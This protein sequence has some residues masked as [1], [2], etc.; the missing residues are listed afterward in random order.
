MEWSGLAHFDAGY[1]S[2]SQLH[3]G[4]IYLL[5]V[6]ALHSPSPTPNQ[7]RAAT[8]LS[9]PERLGW[10]TCDL[11]SLANGNRETE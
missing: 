5:S 7:R 9:S 6:A 8:N 1:F 10:P 2:L 4:A 3:D 11:A